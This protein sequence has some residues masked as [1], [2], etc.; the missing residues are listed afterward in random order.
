MKEGG[1]EG[2][3]A[4]PASRGREKQQNVVGG[5]LR[6]GL[7]KIAS[8]RSFGWLCQRGKKKSVF[9]LANKS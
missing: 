9:P 2:W 5:E 3:G 8:P 6:G 7:T 1:R 4:Q